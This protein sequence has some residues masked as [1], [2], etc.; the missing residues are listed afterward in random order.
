MSFMKAFVRLTINS[1]IQLSVLIGKVPWGWALLAKRQFGLVLVH[2]FS[3][4]PLFLI[5][6]GKHELLVVHSKP[7]YL[8][9]PSQDDILL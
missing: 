9:S 1:S 3:V 6:K 4:L 8:Y 7:S 5:T 2:Q